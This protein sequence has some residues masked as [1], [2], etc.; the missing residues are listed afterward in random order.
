[1]SDEP[2]SP[3][4]DRHETLTVGVIVERRKARTQWQDFVWQPVEVVTL[5]PPLAPWSVM[6][7]EG[8]TARFFAGSF[9]MELHPRETISY[10]MNLDSGAPSIYV[11]LRE[12]ASA[13]QGMALIL[14]SPSPAEAEAYMDGMATVD[15]VPMDDDVT[16]WLAAYVETFHV[17]EQFRKRKR[18]RDK[19]K[20][21]SVP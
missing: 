1:V 7:E 12:E 2:A 13:P 4:L 19:P 14:A 3:S 9:T 16:T 18:G 6:R 20:S 15:K 17:E 21:G 11:V 8:T 10:K 5:V